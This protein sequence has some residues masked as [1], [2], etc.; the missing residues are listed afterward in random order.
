MKSLNG[1]V[2]R[3]SAEN[4]GVRNLSLLEFGITCAVPMDSASRRCTLIRRTVRPARPPNLSCG[5]S[6][7]WGGGDVSWASSSKSSEDATR[8]AGATRDATVRRF[9]PAALRRHTPRP[10]P[11]RRSP[12]SCVPISVPDSSRASELRGTGAVWQNCFRAFDGNR[13]DFMRN[14]AG[15]LCSQIE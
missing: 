6:M 9:R 8:P 11:M 4:P 1:G 13:T 15:C 14:R 7:D 2:G 10:A 3:R 12:Q 5:S